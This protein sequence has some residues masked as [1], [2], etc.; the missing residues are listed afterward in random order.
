MR[1]SLMLAVVLA[2]AAC[3]E[4]QAPQ[5]ESKAPAEA[6]PVPAPDT[7]TPAAPAKA[8]STGTKAPQKAEGPLRDSVI[9]P[10]FTV[11]EKGKVTP[12]KKP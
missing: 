3:G 8:D 11:D 10:K 12:I 5:S 1:A 7:A 2:C 4:K 9:E 6:A